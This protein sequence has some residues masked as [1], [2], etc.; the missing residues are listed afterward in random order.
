MAKKLTAL[1]ILALIF[2]FCSAAMSSDS[3]LE[4]IESISASAEPSIGDLDFLTRAATPSDELVIPARK[5]IVKIAQE[6]FC[7]CKPVFFAAGQ[8]AHLLKDVVARK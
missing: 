4:R 6:H 8:Y 3:R 1:A 2:T 7:E 5:A